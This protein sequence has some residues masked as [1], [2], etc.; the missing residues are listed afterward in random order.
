[1]KPCLLLI[2]AVSFVRARSAKTAEA[3]EVEEDGLTLEEFFEMTELEDD[4]HQ[5]QK[6]EGE[7]SRYAL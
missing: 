6:S 2:L 1:M 4:H 3:T 7:F 5:T